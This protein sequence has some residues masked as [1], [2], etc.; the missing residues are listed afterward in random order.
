[1][2]LK[3]QTK[4]NT[5][6]AYVSAEQEKEEGNTEMLRGHGDCERRANQRQRGHQTAGDADAKFSG[7]NQGVE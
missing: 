1:M 2:S 7:L 3:K 4:L 5:F 6:R